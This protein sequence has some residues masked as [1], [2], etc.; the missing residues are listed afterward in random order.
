MSENGPLE[1][2]RISK[3]IANNKEATMSKA[4][5]SPRN[6][7]DGFLT[8]VSLGR[9]SDDEIMALPTYNM[10]VAQE[11]GHPSRLKK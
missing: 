10:S 2:S 1:M 11:A 9:K 5:L 8:K 3:R 4:A 7:K 6:Y